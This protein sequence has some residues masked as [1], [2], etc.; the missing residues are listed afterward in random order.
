MF[1]KFRK[2]SV[3]VPNDRPFYG[4]FLP[5]TR[6]ASRLLTEGDDSPVAQFEC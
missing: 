3:R 4:P 2:Q 5:R 6:P 1:L